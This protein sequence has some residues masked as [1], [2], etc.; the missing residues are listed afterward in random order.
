MHCVFTWCSEKNNPAVGLAN[1]KGNNQW[2]KGANGQYPLCKFHI[3]EAMSGRWK[4]VVV[5]GWESIPSD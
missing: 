2:T 5:E 4:G 3:E 1:L